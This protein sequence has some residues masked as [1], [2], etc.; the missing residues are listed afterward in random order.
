MRDRLRHGGRRP[1]L[2]RESHGGDEPPQRAP[3]RLVVIDDEHD[4]LRRRHRVTGSRTSN[5]APCVGFALARIQPPC[6]STMEWLI[7]S[8]MPMPSG[9]VVKK[10]LNSCS[11]V[12]GATPTPASCTATT[13]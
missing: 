11:I 3:D 1:G 13:T 8:P 4:G 5:V 9:L 7:D 10:A 2:H 12:S 6:A